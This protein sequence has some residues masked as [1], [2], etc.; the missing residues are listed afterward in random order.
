MPIVRAD[1]PEWLTH[2]QRMEIRRELHGCIERTWFKEHIWV[3]VRTYT[4]EPEERMV[5]MTVEVRGGRGHDRERAEACFDEALD[6]F[7]RVV[8]TTEEEL[9]VLCRKFGQD[10]CISGG[11]ELPPLDTA[12]PDISTIRKRNK[13]RAA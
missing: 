7:S 12:T 2:E 1:V 11:D 4:S 13:K 8:G 6:I 9:I 5:I 10:D 3:A